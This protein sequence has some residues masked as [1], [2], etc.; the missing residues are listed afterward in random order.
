[1]AE[2][3]RKLIRHSIL[4][5]PA[6]LFP[7]LVQFATMI[8]WTHLLHPAA[9]GITAFVIAA[10][11]FTTL[12]GI[13]WWTL[14]MLRF[15]ARFDASGD[16]RFRLMDNLVAVFAVSAQI[17]LTL[18]M[19][20]LAGA[21]ADWAVFISAAGFFIFRTILSHYAEWARSHHHIGV[22]TAAQLIGSGA[23]SALSIAALMIIGPFP[24]VALG[25]LAV[26]YALGL[27]VLLKRTNL[28][29]RVGRFD[30]EIFKNAMRYSL[31]LIVSGIFGW[32]AGNSIRALVQF[33]DGAVGLGLL[34]V[35]WGLGQR[36]A[37]VLAML[38]TAA[39]YPLAVGQMESGD[40]EGALEQ[41]S[42]N[43]V[44]MLALLAPAMAGVTLLS[45]PLVTT[46]IAAQF[47]EATIAI[48]PIAF[49]AA[50]IRGLRIHTSDQTMIL[51]E[52][53]RATTV[54]HYIRGHYECILLHCWTALWR[55]R[56]RRAWHTRG[57]HRSMY[58]LV[59]LLLPTT[60]I[61]RALRLDASAHLHSDRHD[62]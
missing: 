21:P 49:L 4:Y 55:H 7:P 23:S 46:L 43:G 18:P 35:G 9:F 14:F 61:T 15:R 17:A 50:G 31:P 20:W 53:T 3:I 6:Q 30:R 32:V 62:E 25:S 37:A 33:S 13:T 56:R 38:L 29:V 60:S 44:F 34:S 45:S 27:V 5:I 22:F 52:N 28:R 11:E 12:I 54:L 59:C 47:R 19:L 26:G 8:A 40:R 1:M 24:F 58:R 57:N 2:N 39:S 42:L 10:Q 41:V 36:I 16:E 51:L 48:L